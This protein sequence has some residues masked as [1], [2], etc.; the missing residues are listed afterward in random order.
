MTI[1]SKHEVLRTCEGVGKILLRKP[2]EIISMTA[3]AIQLTPNSIDSNGKSNA[4]LLSILY[5]SVLINL[6]IY[7]PQSLNKVPMTQRLNCHRKCSSRINRDGLSYVQEIENAL[8]RIAC[9]RIKVVSS[10]VVEVHGHPW[11]NIWKLSWE[12]LFIDLVSTWKQNLQLLK[13]TCK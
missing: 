13:F 9:A 3:E 12:L 8:V 1:L 11:E 6:Q 2:F 10:E 7:F 5:R 4:V